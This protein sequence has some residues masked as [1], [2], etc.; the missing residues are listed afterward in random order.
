MLQRNPVLN[1][2]SADPSQSTRSVVSDSSLHCLLL[3]LLW[4]ARHK[5][6]KN[7]SQTLWHLL[8]LK[9]LLLSKC[10][11]KSECTEMH[12]ETEPPVL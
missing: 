6:V 3:S 8:N 9:V 5:W 2:N 12:A 10:V 11:V 4:D 7:C 1:A